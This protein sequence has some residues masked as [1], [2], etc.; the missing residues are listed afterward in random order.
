M[1]PGAGTT[2]VALIDSVLDHVAFKHI[3]VGCGKRRGY[4]F[5]SYTYLVGLSR[6]CLGKKSV[7]VTKEKRRRKNIGV[8]FSQPQMPKSSSGTYGG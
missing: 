6:A 8:F 7:F 2:V 3:L 5:E 1:I 4:M